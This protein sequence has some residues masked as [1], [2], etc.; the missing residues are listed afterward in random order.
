M[1]RIAVAGAAGRMGRTIIEAIQRDERAELAVAMERAG[2]DVIGVDAGEL[3]GIGRLERP[4]RDQLEPDDFDV[5][6]EFTNPGATLE[7]LTLC[8]EHGRRMVIGTTG[9]D[10]QDRSRIAEAAA[11]VAVVLAPNMSVGVNLTLKLIE[12]A[13]RTLGG[14]VDVEIVEA[15]HRHKVDA[16]SGTALRM[17]EVVAEALGRDLDRCGVFA[18][19]G[20]TG[21]RPPGAIGFAT[22][23]A[24]DIVGE[25]T[26]LFA[27]AGERIELTHRASSRM[28]FAAGAVRAANWI[29]DRERGLFDMQDVLGL[30]S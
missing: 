4:I 12:I 17:G 27:A 16:P 23:R 5:L 10:D 3:A 9:L 18:R 1:T 2:S 8:R 25:H 26:V 13:A 11:D 21:P 28:T 22:V 19:H 6:I 20:Q 15:H 24:G 29:M 7:H 14:D 30:R